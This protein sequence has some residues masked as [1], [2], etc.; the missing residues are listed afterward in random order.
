MTDKEAGYRLARQYF[1]AVSSGE[2]PD[3]L[4]TPDMTAWITTGGTVSREKYQQMI[5]LLAAMCSEP[6]RFTIKSLT[7]DQDRVVAEAESSGRLIS[8][9]EYANT[10]VFVF[11]IREGRIALVAEHYNALIAQQKLL[12]LM[13][14]AQARLSS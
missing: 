8:G 13:Q 14:A 12:P 1:A 4:L 10:Y 11:R 9:E 7:A 3:A 5:R 2:L 6:L